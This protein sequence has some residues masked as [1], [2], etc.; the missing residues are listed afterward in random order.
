MKKSRNILNIRLP[1]DKR[2]I[3]ITKNVKKSEITI[4][5]FKPTVYVYRKRYH[6]NFFK[7]IIFL[8][9]KLNILNKC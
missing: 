8:T 4:F 9:I 6:L 2:M 7:I 1:C 5:L 3:P